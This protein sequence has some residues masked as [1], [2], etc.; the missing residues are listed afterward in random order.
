[1]AET[2]T[3]EKEAPSQPIVRKRKRGRTR[4]IGPILLVVVLVVAGYFLW[5]YFNTYESTDDAQVDGHL[6]AISARINGQVNEVLVDEEQVVKAGDVL[7]R[8]DPRDY[9]VAVEKA[10]ADLA[11]AQATLAS[12]TTDV[13][14][15]STNTSSTLSSARSVRADAVAG[16]TSAQRQLKAAQARLETS[17]AQVREAEANYKKAADDTARYKLLV[18]KDEIS[19]QIYDQSD[20]TTA[21]ANATIAARTAAVNEAR[22]NVSVSEAA[23]EQA[24]AKIAEAD[25]GIQAALTA[26]QQVAVSQAR[27]RSSAAK[28]AQQKAALDQARLNLKLLHDH[29]A[30]RRYRRQENGGDRPECFAWPATPHCGSDG[31]YL[32][33]RELQGDPTHKD[34]AG[35]EGAVQRGCLQP[36]IYRAP[37]GCRGG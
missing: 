28:V 9:Q 11:D 1:M 2:T 10:A 30:S 5:R 25:A 26:P 34:E 3:P 6:N 36:R 20:Q 12:S 4:I 22:Q 16:L 15:T 7:V 21:A 14:I 24:Q 31:R 32:G 18:A 13:P 17:E 23:I 8:I 27:A 19:Q 29:R 33:N 37:Y 35:A